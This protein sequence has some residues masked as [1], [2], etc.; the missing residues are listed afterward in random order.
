MTNEPLRFRLCPPFFR[1]QAMRVDSPTCNL[2]TSYER[3]A[4]FFRKNANRHIHLRLADMNEFDIGMEA[5][6]EW[7]Q[8]PQLHV[9]VTKLSIGV[10]LITPVYRGKA[11]FREVATDGELAMIVADM[12]KLG[13]IDQE[14][15]ERY[16]EA[17]NAQG[18]ASKVNRKQIIH[19][20]HPIKTRR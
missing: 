19:R 18:T 8:L 2:A 9:L 1:L 6:G 4:A 14:E 12:G 10:H 3:D 17:H 5:V 13:G 16:E 7:L 20:V 11:F 15:F